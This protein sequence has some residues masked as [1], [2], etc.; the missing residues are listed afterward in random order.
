MHDT[1]YADNFDHKCQDQ[2]EQSRNNDTAAGIRKFLSHC[3]IRKFSGIQ[4]GH[5]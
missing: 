2:I 5:R 4:I 3:H 1:L